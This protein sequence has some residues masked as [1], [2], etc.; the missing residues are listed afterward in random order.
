MACNVS[1]RWVAAIGV[2]L[3]TLA[4]ALT[5]RPSAVNALATEAPAPGRHL[6]VASCAGSTCHGRQEP[7]GAV[8]RQDEILHWQDESSPAGAHSRAW[9]VLGGARGRSIAARLGIGDP[10]SARMC[11]GCHA[12][13]AGAMGPSFHLSDGVGCEACH[14][15]ASGWIAG[16]YAVG[17]THAAN[18]ARGMVPLDDPRARANQCLDCHFGSS[19][20]GQ[21]VDHRIMAAGHPRIAFELDLFSTLNR[22]WDEDADYVRRKRQPSAVKTWAVGQAEALSRALALFAEPGRRR[23]GMFPEFYFFDCHSCHRRISDDPAYRPSAIANPGRPIPPGMPPLQDEN[24]IML[25]AAVAVAAPD[26]AG[27]LNADSR[28][29]HAAIAANEGAAVAAAARL[30]GTAQ[31]LS[32]RFA[33]ARLGR[34]ETFAIIDAVASAAAA[35][36]TD[37]E[38]SAQAVMAIDTL[39]SSLVASGD[40][41]R[42]AATAIRGDID[43]AYQAVR[44]PNGYQPLAFRA[45]LASA[46]RAIGALK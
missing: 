37:Y 43:R 17:A 4:I 28:A 6:G 12:D 13:P 34:R 29:F 14:G 8:V 36:Y 7:T 23:E 46:A 27:R 3:L 38:G 10:Q 42:G 31:A 2:L 15:G 45:S 1:L 22:H 11:L 26:M 20:A 32:S 18:V 33:G 24:M 40:V 19:R 35:R 39:L 25:S 30:R 16:H 5:L 21:W 9:R 41:P 44:D